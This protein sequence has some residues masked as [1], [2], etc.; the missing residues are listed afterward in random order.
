M[1]LVAELRIGIDVG[2]TGIKAG[3]VDVTSGT[4]E[5]ERHRIDTP[6]PATPAAVVDVIGRLL[7][8]LDRP[9]AIG[10][11][12][13]S[14]VVDGMVTTAHNIDDGW[15]GQNARSLIADSTGRRVVV[16]NDADA[17]GM[18]EARFGAARATSGKVLVLTFG[19][20]IGSALLVDGE[21]MPNLE[22]G[23]VEFDGVLPAEDKFSAKAREERGLDWPEW[24][25]EIARYIAMVKRVINPELIVLGGGAA[26]RWEKFTD[27][28]PPSLGVVRAHLSNNAG[29][30]GAALVA[31]KD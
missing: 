17:A 19:T 25:T 18:A 31:P 24:G 16:I 26:K 10:V 29:I 5:S 21:L 9:G 8:E 6:H 27:S 14:V 7:E 12:F 28:L 13:P 22:L 4:L 2:G 15:I 3:L 11:G 23:Q 20:G 1:P 30:V